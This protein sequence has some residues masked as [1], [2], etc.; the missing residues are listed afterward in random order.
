MSMHTSM[1][2]HIHAGHI[3]AYEHTPIHKCAHVENR[4]ER[5]LLALHGGGQREEDRKKR[6]KEKTKE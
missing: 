6:R 5:S 1:H 3:S 2:A 4:L